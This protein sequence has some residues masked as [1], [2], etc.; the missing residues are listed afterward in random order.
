MSVYH[1]VVVG[2]DGSVPARK[3]INHA[4]WI[5]AAADAKLIIV[6]AFVHHEASETGPATDVAADALK[7]GGFMMHGDAPA[8]EILHEAAEVAKAAGA[9]DIELRP[10]AGT[11]VDVLTHAAERG[12]DLLVVGN[13]GMTGIAGRV[14]GSVPASVSH[15]AKCDVLIVHT[16]D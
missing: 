10:V 4:A 1:T 3:A 15:K 5:A 14:F 16:R 2:T 11:P 7:E 12:V 8:R 6:N 13:K 9:K